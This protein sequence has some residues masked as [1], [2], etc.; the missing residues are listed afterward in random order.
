VPGRDA[1][2]DSF[3]TTGGGTIAMRLDDLASTVDLSLK[4][5]SSMSVDMGGATQVVGSEATT[6]ITVKP[7]K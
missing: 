6:R 5:S 3:A 4:T 7:V 2:L 1:K